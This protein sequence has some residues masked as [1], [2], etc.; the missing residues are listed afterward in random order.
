VKNTDTR[1]EKKILRTTIMGVSVLSFVG[2]IFLLISF[3][4]DKEV[5]FSEE[6]IQNQILKGLDK[7]GLQKGPSPH[8]SLKVVKEIS[9]KD[10]NMKISDGQIHAVVSVEGTL[11]ASK[12]FSLTAKAV[13]APQYKNGAFYFSPTNIKVESFE[14][15][16]DKPGVVISKIA[17]RY[18][19]DDKKKLL[20]KDIAPVIESWMTTTAQ[21]A[22]MF[23]LE[24]RPV[25]TLKNDVK[26]VLIKSSLESVKIQGNELVLT[27][28]VWEFGLSVVIG[29]FLL[30]A[31]IAMVLALAQSP[32][33]GVIAIAT[34]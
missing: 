20:M 27:F 11:I 18:I 9:I 33:L 15:E 14:Y 6:Q 31:S 3:F 29:I 21:N 34:P 7:K 2:A 25:Y 23:V 10:V 12:K 8:T 5:H 4:G 22:V 28:S 1:E 19:T 17:D 26:G 24:K 13:G 16:G 32:F 30:I